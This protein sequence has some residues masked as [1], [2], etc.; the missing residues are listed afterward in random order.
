MV[1]LLIVPCSLH[2]LSFLCSGFWREQRDRES[3]GIYP[4]AMSTTKTTPPVWLLALLG[5]INQHN[6]FHPVPP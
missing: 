3:T 1:K 2:L 5:E 6:L 4:P